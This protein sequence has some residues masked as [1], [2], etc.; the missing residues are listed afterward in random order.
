[1]DMPTA[2]FAAD[3]DTLYATG[4]NSVLVQNILRGDSEDA[5][6]AITDI[7][8]A[9]FVKLPDGT[10]LV[11]E[12]EVAYSLFDILMLL[13]EQNPQA[14]ETFVNTWNK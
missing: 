10:V 1:M 5:D 12:N 11:S 3:E 2:D 6:R 8:A 13:K 14:Y 7:Y 9:S 4:T